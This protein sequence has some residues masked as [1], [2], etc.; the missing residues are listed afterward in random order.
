MQK[1]GVK[2]LPGSLA[3]TLNELDKDEV[4]KAA[5]ATETYEAFVSAKWKEWDGFRLSVSDYETE[6]YLEKA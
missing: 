3:E 2:E 4:V 1:L 5:L 6:R